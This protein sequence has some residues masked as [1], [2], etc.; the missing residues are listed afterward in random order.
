[1]LIFCFIQFINHNVA[2]LDPVLL[3]FISNVRVPFSMH[4]YYENSI[5]RYVFVFSKS[6][7][8]FKYTL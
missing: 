5:I 3:A 4:S 8:Y 1:M 7:N 2:F 6:G